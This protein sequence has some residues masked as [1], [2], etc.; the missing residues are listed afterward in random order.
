MSESKTVAV[1]ALPARPADGH[2]GTFG[3][4][5]VVGGSA[6]M[7]GAP[8]LCA[9]AAFRGG[10]GLV[11][12]AAPRKVLASV[13]RYHPS[14]TGMGRSGLERVRGDGRSVLAVG[15]GLGQGE[16][17]GE[18]VERL[19]AYQNPLV[20]DAD[21]LNL[22]AERGL[23]RRGGGPWVL[24][25]HPGEYRRLAEARGLE[26]DPIDPERRPEAARGLSEATGGVVVL[27]GQHTLVAEGRR[28][29]RNTT[30]NP[31]LSTAGSGDVLTGLIAALMAQGL[32]AFE[33]AVLGV[34]LHGRAAD[35]WA[36]EHG[37]RGMTAPELAD[38]LLPAMVEHD[39]QLSAG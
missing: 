13:L 39:R 23:E 37:P 5:V 30:G 26:G 20:L 3:T 4:V 8:A 32:A 25:P 12:V 27:K 38:R 33:A 36:A 1:P 28:L 34:H 2:K 16:R 21:G 15:P 11:K 29:F 10:A 35:H 31:S 9:L 19:L 6:R 14:V 17:A 22:L 7:P 24:T 18:I